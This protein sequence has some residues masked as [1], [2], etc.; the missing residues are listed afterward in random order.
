MRPTC[1]IVIASLLAGCSATGAPQFDSGESEVEMGKLRPAIAKCVGAVDQLGGEL[2]DLKRETEHFQSDFDR[3][4]AINP[5]I[6]TEYGEYTSRQINGVTKWHE[7]SIRGS[8]KSAA[9]EC[10]PLKSKF[11]ELIGNLSPE[12]VHFDSFKACQQMIGYVDQISSFLKG[13]NDD[14]IAWDDIEPSFQACQGWAA[15]PEA[16]RPDPVLQSTESSEE[17]P[18]NTVASDIP[19]TWSLIKENGSGPLQAIYGPPES[20]ASMTVE[21]GI[22]G[23]NWTFWET[24]FPKGHV[25]FHSDS[26]FNAEVVFVDNDGMERSEAIIPNDIGIKSSLMSGKNL[27]IDGEQIPVEKPLL[28]LVSSCDGLT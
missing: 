11:D 12:T 20:S 17:A 18:T 26:Y 25:E 14:M 5:D 27:Y 1:V 8:A 15:P 6:A 10:S 4:R 22:K 16:K 23:L 13:N 28:T 24:R 3:V 21:C 7:D 2:L 9:H 19:E